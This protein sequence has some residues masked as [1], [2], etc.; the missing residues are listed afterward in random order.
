MQRQKTSVLLDASEYIQDLK[1][2]LQELNQLVAATAQKIVDY[3]PMP[4]V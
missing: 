2:R 3:D 4:M 1:Q